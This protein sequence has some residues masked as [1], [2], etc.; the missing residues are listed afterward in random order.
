MFEKGIKEKEKAKM[1]KVLIKT[2]EVVGAIMIVGGL[3]GIVF[4]RNN[5]I[6]SGLVFSLIGF[7]LISVCFYFKLGLM[8][9][10]EANLSKDK[11]CCG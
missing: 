6:I 3:P 7:V 5:K 11:K 9:S 2:M 4:G 8:N 1:P 10:R